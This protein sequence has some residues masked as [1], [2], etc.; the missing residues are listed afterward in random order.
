MP[1]DLFRE[2]H[3]RLVGRADIGR[4]EGDPPHLRG[5]RIGQFAPAVPDIDVP[6]P[7]EAVDEFAPVGEVQHRAAPLG[8]E[9]RRF[10]LLGVVQR[11]NQKTP[12]AFKQLRGAVH[13]DRL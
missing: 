8:H 4:G 10:V 1:D 6:Q 5:R 7:G 12:V 3:R 11:M 2:A 13:R 9:Q